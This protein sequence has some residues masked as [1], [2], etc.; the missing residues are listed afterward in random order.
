MRPDRIVV[1]ECRGAEALDMVQAL[2]TGHRGALTTCHANDPHDALQRIETMVLAA[3][4]GL[5]AEVVR[6][7][8]RSA[9]DVVVQVERGTGGRRYVEAVY[10]TVRS[11]PGAA[12]DPV[13]PTTM[14]W[15]ADRR[16]LCRRVGRAA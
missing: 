14:R 8:V 10:E 13:A 4:A 3:G 6:A 5:S 1:G 7:Q 11:G 16:G 2:H 12:S 9:L 15:L